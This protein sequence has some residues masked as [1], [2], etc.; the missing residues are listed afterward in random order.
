MCEISFI[1][2]AMSRA[3]NYYQ[4]RYTGAPNKKVIEVVPLQ[5]TVPST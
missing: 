1:D 4:T 5:L 2:A 3:L